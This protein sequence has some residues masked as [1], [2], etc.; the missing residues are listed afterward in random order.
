MKSRQ[1][2]R[3]KALA[4]RSDSSVDGEV[5]RA[6]GSIGNRHA[7]EQEQ[8]CEEYVARGEHVHIAEGCG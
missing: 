8:K 1:V 3:A 5:V 2:M 7:G 6:K 4:R